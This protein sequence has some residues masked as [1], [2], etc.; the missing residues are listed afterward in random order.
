MKNWFIASL[1]ALVLSACAG[2]SKMTIDSE[3]K[4]KDSPVRNI[5]LLDED[6]DPNT[7]QQPPSPVV[8]KAGQEAKSQEID[9]SSHD[10]K[11]NKDYQVLGY[12]VQI[13]QTQDPEEA[14]RVQND[15]I[16]EL[17]TEVYSIFD[18]P[19]HKVRVGDFTIRADAEQLLQTVLQKGYKGAW[20]VRTKINMPEKPEGV[21]EE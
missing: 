15:A 13:L 19:Y 21:F 16:L 12:R 7:L 14:R 2:G 18:S 6:F 5:H 3:G 4:D 10:S 17:D 20:I 9:L 11:S 1:I 8:P